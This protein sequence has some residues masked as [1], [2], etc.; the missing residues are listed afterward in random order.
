MF[1]RARARYSSGVRSSLLEGYEEETLDNE[2]DSNVIMGLKVDIKG[3]ELRDRLI[4]L[5]ESFR[6]ARHDLLSKTEEK[7]R[8]LKDRVANGPGDDDE[9]ESEDQDEID[10]AVPALTS[11]AAK[12]SRKA[13]EKGARLS[14]LANHAKFVADHVVLTKTYRLDANRV[15]ELS[16]PTAVASGQAR[17]HG[18]SDPFED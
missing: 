6:T 13:R 10:G 18:M 2:S 4:T 17:L 7:I 16:D 5:A 11:K 12:L 3:T 9:D 1:E 8:R 15:R 14:Q